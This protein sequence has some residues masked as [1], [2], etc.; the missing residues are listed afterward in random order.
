MLLQAFGVDANTIAI[1]QNDISIPSQNVQ[2]VGPDAPVVIPTPVAP[3]QST[4]PQPTFG[5]ISAPVVQSVQTPMDTDPFLVFQISIDTLAQRNPPPADNG[6]PAGQYLRITVNKPAN[7]FDFVASTT[8]PQGV[9]LGVP[10][11]EGV[12]QGGVYK[13]GGKTW[14]GYYYEAEITGATGNVPITLTDD[15]KNTITRTIPAN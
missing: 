6:A 1:V 13:S 14:A 15:A 8:L 11:Y 3:V 9:S 5:A 12:N 2:I 7:E 10:T 4:T